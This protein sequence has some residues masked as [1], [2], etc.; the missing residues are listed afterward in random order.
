LSKRAVSRRRSSRRI[1]TSSTSLLTSIPAVVLLAHFSP[2]AYLPFRSPTLHPRLPTLW[3]PAASDTPRHR[4]RGRGADL[5]HK[6]MAS[7][8]HGLP[9]TPSSPT[10]KV[11][12]WKPQIRRM[13]RWD[14]KTDV[15]AVVPDRGSYGFLYSSGGSGLHLPV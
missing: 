5:T 3:M 13:L 9:G 2:P 7:R 10:P 15:F 12:T 11:S 1:A 14:A 6:L 4:R 8:Q